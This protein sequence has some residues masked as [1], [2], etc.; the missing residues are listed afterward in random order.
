MSAI[1]ID[2]IFVAGL[3]LLAFVGLRIL[4]AMFDTRSL[5]Q[6]AVMLLVGV[7]MMIYAIS[8]KPGGY[9]VENIPA[10]VSSVAR[11]LF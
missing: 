4:G 7:A 6:A 5:R 11:G 3:F 8:E 10:L 1:W 9:Q 2:R